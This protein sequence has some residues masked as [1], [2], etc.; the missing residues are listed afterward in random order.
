MS[1]NRLGQFYESNGGIALASQCSIGVD[2]SEMSAT[3]VISTPA[4][5]RQ[6]DSLNPLG[7]S[8]EN[9]RL[10]PVVFWD[11]GK[12]V[13]TPIAK[14][15][16]DDRKLLLYP[17]ADGI[18]AK[19][20]FS[21]RNK[22]SEQIFALVADD[23]IHATSIRFQPLERPVS[24]SEGL[25]YEVWDMEEWSWCGL[26][27]NPEAVRDVVA[28]GRIAGSSIDGSILK[29]LTGR[30][31]KSSTT[32][33]TWSD[34]MNR[35][36]KR[37]PVRK[38]RRKLR[39]ADVLDPKK[40]YGS[41]LMV[42]THSHLKSITRGLDVGMDN[43]ENPRVRDLL[44]GV[45]AMLSEVTGALEGGYSEEY[46][47]MEKMESCPTCKTAEMGMLDE[48]LIYEDEE[49][50]MMYGEDEE[51]PSEMMADLESDEFM[52]EEDDELDPEAKR[53][54]R[55]NMPVEEVDEEEQ[56]EVLK[57]YLATAN[58]DRYELGSMT[59]TLR[60][61]AHAPNLTSR[62]K[63]QVVKLNNRIT[64][65]VKSAYRMQGGAGIGEQATLQRKLKTLQS[66]IARITGALDQAVPF[67]R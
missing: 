36:R 48:E 35:R 10:N 16:D 43:L 37:R 25:R 49:K 2:E 44:D 38:S 58:M 3:A 6:N 41:Q 42:A 33:V 45:K 26:G 31:P 29:S 14:C 7:G 17:S 57:S 50:N 63:S 11:H 4:W 64:S 51:M 23:I 47:E 20:I 13:S 18:K 40:P 52:L 28:K 53:Y 67:R 59:T 66:E 39:V 46:P 54:G 60:D 32:K 5:D 12:D 19:S 9:Y 22:I 55:K 56:E 1:N 21:S 61:L 65:L 24:K 15:I 30:M 27:V 62:Q 8:Y 34:P